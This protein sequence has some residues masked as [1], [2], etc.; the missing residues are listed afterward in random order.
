MVGLLLLGMLGG[1]AK[2]VSD[3]RIDESTAAMA[4]MNPEF[5]FCN[6]CR[7][8]TILIN[9]VPLGWTE[10]Q[11]EMYEVAFSFWSETSEFLFSN[12]MQQ[13]YHE[14]GFNAYRDAFLAVASVDHPSNE[15]PPKDLALS[16][17]KFGWRGRYQVSAINQLQS[18]TECGETIGS[19]KPR[20]G[21]GDNADSP[22]L[23]HC[24]DFVFHSGEVLG[25]KIEPP[26]VQDS[27][28]AVVFLSFYSDL[29]ADK[30]LK[31]TAR[32]AFYFEKEGVEWQFVMRRDR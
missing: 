4:K 15:N 17:E 20:Q 30:R 5:G 26:I 1:C 24:I 19:E 14:V 6:Q 22:S 16:G 7:D 12:S 13:I 23:L 25:V 29:E 9:P 3:H 21:P 28:T 10:M 2:T 18:A 32:H 31:K 8:T 27:V 11:K